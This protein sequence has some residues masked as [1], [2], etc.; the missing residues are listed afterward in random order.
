MRNLDY[1]RPWLEC[2]SL[3]KN[4]IEQ[5]TDGSRSSKATDVLNAQVIRIFKNTLPEDDGWSFAAEKRI[6]CSRGDTFT[7]D[8]LVYKD[9]TLR[10]AV[11]LKAIQKSYNKNRHNYANTLAGE[12][13]RIKDLPMH[14]GVSVIT[15]DW[16][17]REVPVGDKMEQT[18]IPDTSS[19]ESRWN[20]FLKDG[21]FVSFNKIIF[22]VS[23]NTAINIQGV[24]KLQDTIERL[25][26]V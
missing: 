22:D 5:G 12:V 24:E 14:K 26:L 20:K 15:I 1:V 18:K 19:A 6:P 13:E 10:A 25:K 8:V 2:D 4:L 3:R 11:L 9:K 21:S 7:V 23:G 17:P 16:V